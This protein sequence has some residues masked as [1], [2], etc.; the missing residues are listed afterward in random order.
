MELRLRRY[1]HV[2]RHARTILMNGTFYF[3]LFFLLTNKIVFKLNA[4]PHF[5]Y[6]KLVTFGILHH[7]I[8]CINK[9]PVC[10]SV[11]PINRQKFYTGAHHIDEICCRTGLTPAKIQDDIDKDPFVVTICK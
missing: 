11:N 1:A 8:R 5:D 2:H 4:D 6:R 3:S 10:I 7:L 9:Y